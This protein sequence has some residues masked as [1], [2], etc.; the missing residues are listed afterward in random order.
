[1]SECASAVLSNNAHSRQGA[2]ICSTFIALLLFRLVGKRSRMSFSVVCSN[3][4]MGSRIKLRGF[5][6]C[7][8]GNFDS[9]AN[10]GRAHNALSQFMH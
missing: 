2:F 9:S 8:M 7:I 1:M 6:L 5:G 3:L 10:K 4:I